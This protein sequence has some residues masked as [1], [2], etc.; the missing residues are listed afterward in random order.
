[1]DHSHDKDFVRQATSRLA[2]PLISL[3][4]APH[5]IQYIALRNIKFILDKRPKIF[6]ANIKIFFIKYTDPI[7]VKLEKI[8][9]LKRVV[10]MSNIDVVISEFKEYSRDFDVDCMRSAISAIG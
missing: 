5:E 4:T 2:N 3:L 8:E 10:N 9:V 7:Y 1:M 6:D